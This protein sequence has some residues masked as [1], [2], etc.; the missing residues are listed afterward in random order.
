MTKDPSIVVV[1][2]LFPSADQP[3]AG[4]FIRERMFRVGKRLPL[5]VVSPQPWFPGQSL[6]RLLHPSY[7][8][9]GVKHETMD[10]I[11]IYRPRFFSL[12]AF[13]RWLD[14]FSLGLCTLNHLRKLKRAERCDII[15]AH[16][17]YPDGAGAA[18][19]GMVLKT[20]VS[21]TLRGTEPRHLRQARIRKRLLLGL[22]RTTQIFSVSSSLKKVVEQCG[23]DADKVLVVGNGV[24]TTRFKVLPKS[25]ARERLGLSPRARVVVTVGGLVERKGFHR[26]MEVLPELIV[27]YPDLVY[28]IVGGA[29]RE[30][31]WSERLRRLSEELRI[32][33]HVRFL[34]ELEPDHLHIPLSASD[35]FVLSSR[36]EG[37]ANVILEAMACGLPVLASDVGGNRE[38]VCNDSYGVIFPFDD[39]AA[40]LAALKRGFTTAWD[41]EAI[42]AY[43]NAND[44]ERRVDL[45]C[46]TFDRM[47]RQASNDA[48]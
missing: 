48:S 33:Q 23:V 41:N 9:A 34:G 36:N 40:L 20:P 30:G 8:K 13:G 37:W 5:T 14:G 39:R 42:I 16:F 1:S 18:F 32:T 11:E 21:V 24:D 46:E 2:T 6:I 4:I 45:L 31:D 25:E 29:S 35:L 7:R 43:A 15:D 22:H 26:V 17:A 44:W 47:I 28:L 10:G 3:S 38:V 19:V 27:D 12:P